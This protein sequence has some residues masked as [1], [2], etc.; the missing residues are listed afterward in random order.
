[1]IQAFILLVVSP[2]RL[3]AIGEQFGDSKIYLEDASSKGQSKF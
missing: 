3:H 1:M 2:G